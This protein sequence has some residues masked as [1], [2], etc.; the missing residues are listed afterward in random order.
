MQIKNRQQLLTVVAIA[1]VAL[2]A[3]IQLVLSPL[4]KIW[5]TRATRI[6]D[7]RKNIQRANQDD[8]ARAT[9]GSEHRPPMAAND[10]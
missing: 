8:P 1:A 3:G 2:F 6:A 5:S 9:T 7:L 10:K 4:E